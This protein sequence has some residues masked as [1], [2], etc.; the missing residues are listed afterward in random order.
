MKATSSISNTSARLSRLP[1]CPAVQRPDNRFAERVVLST[2]IVKGRIHDFEE[3]SESAFLYDV[4][5]LGSW[6]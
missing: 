5:H 6:L 3:G 2:A 1:D 4:E